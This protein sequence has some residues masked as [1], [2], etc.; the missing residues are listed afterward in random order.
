MTRTRPLTKII[1]SLL[2]LCGIALFAAGCG[3]SQGGTQG[4]SQTPSEAGETDALL[5]TEVNLEE[6]LS[7]GLPVIL[8][9]G[10]DSREAKGTL[11]NLERINKLYGDKILIRSVDLAANPE[12]KEGFPVQVIPSQFFYTAEGK[13]IT[14]P[15]DLGI[16]MSSFQSLETQEIIFTVHEGTLTEQ[17]LLKILAYMDVK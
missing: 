12:A 16:L 9:F 1:A 13:A 8:N 7:Q 17:E 5:I 11:A 14:L 10:D 4:G 15:G 6:L 3:G 2:L